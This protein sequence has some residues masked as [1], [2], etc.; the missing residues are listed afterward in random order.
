MSLPPPRRLGRSGVPVSALTLGAM[1]LGATGT[2]ANTEGSDAVRIV[3]AALDAGVTVI[4]TADAYTQGASEVLVGE[5]LAGGRRDSVVLA[6]KFHNQIG[7]DPAN[8]G[9]SRRWITRAVEGSLRRLGTDRIDLYQ[10]HR[11]APETDLLET[12]QALDGLVRQ[13]KILYYGTSVFAPE[14]L[15]EAQWLAKTN[16]LIAP[17]TEQVPYSILIRGV[18]RATLPVARR[19][20][21]GVLSY[22]PLA[23]GWL[24]GAYRR[25]AA[26]PETHRGEKI[27]GRYALDAPANQR[28]LDAAD[29]I[30]RL[31]DEAGL[32]V[33][34]LALGF[35]L[36]NPTISSVIVGPRTEAH[37]DS[38]LAA[39]AAPLD[40]A[41][42]A[43]LDEIVAPGT[44][45]IE[46]DTGTILPALTP[47]GL[48]S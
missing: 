6:T 39:A 28:K 45:F 43:R 31:A 34:D 23:A 46:R 12:L 20:G 8:R 11:P 38:Y 13:G 24:S 21:L 42:L 1:N 17:L 27:P 14:D 7:D 9:N 40:P 32:R 35:A 25:G 37:L 36:A 29:A 18:E 30:A 47:E 16:H 19:F 3:H 15:V 5:A 44:H 48:R 2:G 4:D 26:Q 10:A 41:L 22:G 33:I